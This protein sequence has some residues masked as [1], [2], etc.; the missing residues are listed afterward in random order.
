MPCHRCG[1]VQEDPV[2]GASP[3]ARGVIDEQQILV[4]PQC[5]QEEPAWSSKLRSCTQC[6]STRLQIQMG[7]IVCRQC[8]ATI[9]VE[10]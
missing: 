10:R 6:G 1:R 8:N 7:L 2:R 5:Q 9:E 3:W 4:C